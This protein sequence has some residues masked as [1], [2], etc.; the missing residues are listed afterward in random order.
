MARPTVKSRHH[1]KHS[2]MRLD[3]AQ[4]IDTVLGSTVNTVG[5]AYLIALRERESSLRPPMTLHLNSN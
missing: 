2:T 5:R 3:Y 4:N 1:N